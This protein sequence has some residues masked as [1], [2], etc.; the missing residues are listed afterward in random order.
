[1]RDLLKEFDQVVRMLHENRIRYAVV[2]GLAMAV[3]G[4]V[5]ATRDMDFLVHPDDMAA[6]ADGLERLGYHKGELWRINDSPLILHRW[7]KTRGRGEDLSILDVLESGSRKYTGMIGRARVKKW[8]AGL[9]V[10]VAQRKDLIRM[11]ADRKS[12]ADQADIEFLKEA[13][14]DE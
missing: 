6:L 7:W 13:G 8:R 5:R 10:R 4:G 11:K 2:G 3:Y 9:T 14:R 12:H 1:M